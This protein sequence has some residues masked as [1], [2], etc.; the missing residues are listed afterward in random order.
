CGR[1]RDRRQRQGQRNKQGETQGSHDV[2]LVGGFPIVL[3][4]RRSRA[5]HLRCQDDGTGFGGFPPRRPSSQS[6]A[7]ASVSNTLLTKPAFMP[8]I[9][10]YR[11]GSMNSG[12]ATMATRTL[13]LPTLDHS[14]I[15]Q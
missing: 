9:T 6:S 3:P 8:A 5:A 2:F 12:L 11:S 4:K 7:C 10:A 1:L 13:P 15:N 14:S